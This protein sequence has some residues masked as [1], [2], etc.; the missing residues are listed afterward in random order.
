MSFLAKLWQFRS[1]RET[2]RIGKSRGSGEHHES[3]SNSNGPPA[4]KGP[5]S[6]LAKLT[7]HDDRCNMI[8]NL[9]HV[10]L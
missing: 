4:A 9:V 3:N 7:V 6:Q 5:R 8:L 2:T 10:E 1:D